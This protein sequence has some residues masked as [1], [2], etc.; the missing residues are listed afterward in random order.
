MKTNDKVVLTTH[1]SLCGS[2]PVVHVIHMMACKCARL[3]FNSR[4]SSVGGR[5]LNAGGLAESFAPSVFFFHSNNLQTK[6]MVK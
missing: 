3:I 2:V 5:L 6:I 1:G 4:A